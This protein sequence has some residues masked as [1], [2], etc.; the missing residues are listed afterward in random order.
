MAPLLRGASVNE[1]WVYTVTITTNGRA[2]K[3]EARGSDEAHVRSA[4]L[5][6]VPEWAQESINEQLQKERPWWDFGVRHG[7][8]EQNPGVTG[9][10]TVYVA[11]KKVQEDA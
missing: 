3:E 8:V 6:Y 9:S 5:G 1:T 4:A 2:T 11:G 10:T 7:F